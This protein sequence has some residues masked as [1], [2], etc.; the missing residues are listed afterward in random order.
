MKTN[1]ATNAKKSAKPD[2]ANAVDKT[3][4]GTKEARADSCRKSPCRQRMNRE[5]FRQK[6]RISKMTGEIEV[7][8]KKLKELFRELTSPRFNTL[9]AIDR[10]ITLTMFNALEA[11]KSALV[12]KRHWERSRMRT[13]SGDRLH[14]SAM[15]FWD[16]TFGRAMFRDHGK[17]EKTEKK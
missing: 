1:K 5:D 3:H 11:Y 16:F 6:V 15:D 17:V 14:T 10:H 9:P 12:M 2:R 8:T 7:L 4:N 13:P